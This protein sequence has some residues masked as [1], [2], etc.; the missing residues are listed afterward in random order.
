MVSLSSDDNMTPIVAL[1]PKQ[2]ISNWTVLRCTRKGGQT[3]ISFHIILGINIQKHTKAQISIT[4][5]AHTYKGVRAVSFPVNTTN[6]WVGLTA[7]VFPSFSASMDSVNPV[8]GGENW[9]TWTN[10]TGIWMILVPLF[11]DLPPNKERMSNRPETLQVGNVF[12][13]NRRPWIATVKKQAE[14]S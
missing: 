3:H 14:V 6:T 2:T 8:L 1:K 4:T 7:Q 13:I 12:N 9:P 10:P 11:T 5:I